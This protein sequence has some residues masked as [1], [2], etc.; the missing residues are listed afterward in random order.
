MAGAAERAPAEHVAF[1]RLEFV[2]DAKGADARPLEDDE[3]VGS[4]EMMDTTDDGVAVARNV[5]A[6]APPEDTGCL[7][8][9][10]IDDF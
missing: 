2:W 10:D 4:Q 3:V 1:S 8:D 5:Q 7:E 6:E 9:D